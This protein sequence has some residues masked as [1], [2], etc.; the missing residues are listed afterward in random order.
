Q[1]SG[2]HD[3]RA[4][5]PGED[6]SVR[7]RDGVRRLDRPRAIHGASGLRAVAGLTAPNIAAAH[8]LAAL[9]LDRSVRD[10]EPA[11]VATLVRSTLLIEQV[12]HQV[13]LGRAARAGRARHQAEVGGELA[14]LVAAVERHRIDLVAVLELLDLAL[15]DLGGPRGARGRDV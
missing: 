15:Q 13:A 10:A 11:A 2:R 1:A 4:R 5:L 3:L 9:R 7:E 12:D 6:R 14:A 8:R